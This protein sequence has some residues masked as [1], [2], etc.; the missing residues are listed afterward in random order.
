MTGCK[1]LLCDFQSEDGPKVTF[2]D[3]STGSTKGYG[4]LTNG[5]I[6]FSKVAYV[7]GLK[8][9]L[10]SISQQCDAELAMA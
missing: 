3:N 5:T 8:H 2:G 1:P 10:I 7:D 6:S 4:V 9:N